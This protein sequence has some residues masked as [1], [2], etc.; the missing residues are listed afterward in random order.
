[1]FW[2][3]VLLSILTCCLHFDLPYRF[4]KIR[5]NKNAQRYYTPKYQT[6]Y[7]N[8]FLLKPENKFW[9]WNMTEIENLLLLCFPKQCKTKQADC[10]NHNNKNMLKTCA[11]LAQNVKN[12]RKFC[13]CICHLPLSC[14]VCT[15]SVKLWQIFKFGNFNKFFYLTRSRKKN[16]KTYY[17]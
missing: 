6:R 14:I 5:P 10:I 15:C 8:V 9:H 17:L 13:V 7:V 2:C 16:C 11:F 4:I 3:I 1:M 12:V